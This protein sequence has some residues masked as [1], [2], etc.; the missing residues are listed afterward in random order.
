MP[1]QHDP[2][3]LD[4]V[5]LCSRDTTRR[6]FL[7]H[8]I[9]FS[10]SAIVGSQLIQGAWAGR[11]KAGDKPFDKDQAESF[12]RRAIELSRKG[13]EAGDGGPFGAVI[14]K[15]GQIVGEGWNRVVRT[16]DPTA[17]GEV[18]AIRDACKR[19]AS[20]SLTG[21]DLYTTGE[22][23]PMCFGSIYWARIDRV[24]FGFSVKDAAAIGF[25]DQFIYEQLAKPLDQRLIPE[26]QLLAREALQV[27]KAYASDPT[28][29][30]Y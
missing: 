16:K 11:P 23:C 30:K 6:S 19:L 5:G 7:T 8:T 20:F 28:R 12:M 13:V 21:C 3:L 17:H 15:D 25:D 18:V 10:L 24:F 14:V 27:A 26:S 2:Y 1:E 9:G 22:P 29:V 4:A